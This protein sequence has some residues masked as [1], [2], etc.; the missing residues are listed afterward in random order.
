MTAGMNLPSKGGRTGR[1]QA[2]GAVAGTRLNRDHRM[3]AEE[4]ARCRVSGARGP[5]SVSGFDAPDG[6]AGVIG[7][8]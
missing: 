8:E 7:D 5:S 1:Q 3:A 4:V 6:V 2:A